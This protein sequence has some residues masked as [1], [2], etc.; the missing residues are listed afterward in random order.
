MEVPCDPWDVNQ[1]FSGISG[2]KIV[3]F[4]ALCLEVIH[5]SIFPREEIAIAV[6]EALSVGKA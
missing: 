4:C 6:L 2:R 5:Q 3:D 1:H